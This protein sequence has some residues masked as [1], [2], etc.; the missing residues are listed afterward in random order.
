MK[1][2]AYCI[3]YIFE[4]AFTNNYIFLQNIEKMIF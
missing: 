3:F 1:I 2:L 4:F